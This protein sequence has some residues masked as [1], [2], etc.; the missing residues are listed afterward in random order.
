M[1]SYVIC[2]IFKNIY[3]E[4]HPQTATFINFMYERVDGGHLDHTE[5]MAEWKLSDPS[6]LFKS[7]KWSN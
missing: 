6:N 1:F 3:F 4:E 7:L 2:E 5:D